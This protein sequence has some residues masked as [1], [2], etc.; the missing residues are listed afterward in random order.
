[1]HAMKPTI[2]VAYNLIINGVDCMDQICS[3]KH[4]DKKGGYSSLNFYVAH[5]YGLPQCTL[6]IESLT[7]KTHNKL[8]MREIKRQLVVQ[9]MM[10][11]IKPAKSSSKPVWKRKCRPKLQ[12]IFQMAR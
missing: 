7:A 11:L 1:M 12:G 6:H 3:I 10:P 5:W 4:G 8:P 9:L 2:V